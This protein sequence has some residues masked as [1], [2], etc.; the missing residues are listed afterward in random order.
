MHSCRHHPCWAVKVNQNVPL[1]GKKRENIRKRERDKKTTARKF[2]Y[3][4][5][6]PLGPAPPLPFSSQQARLQF[7][8]VKYHLNSMDSNL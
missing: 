5:D 4:I 8:S 3:A 1:D 7:Y 6:A 2:C